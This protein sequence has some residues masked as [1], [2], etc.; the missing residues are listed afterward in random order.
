MLPVIKRFLYIFNKKSV[1]NTLDVVF[2]EIFLL[3][4][5]NSTQFCLKCMINFTHNRV[6]GLVIKSEHSFQ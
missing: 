6:I 1:F 3:P 2:G 4:P 5:I